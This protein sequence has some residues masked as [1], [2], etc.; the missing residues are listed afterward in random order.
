MLCHPLGCGGDFKFA[1]AHGHAIVMAPHTATQAA[2]VETW[3][4]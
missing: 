3:Q 4:T 2:V 1:R